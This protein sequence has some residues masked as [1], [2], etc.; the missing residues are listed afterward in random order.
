MET[1]EKTNLPSIQ[2]I[3]QGDINIPGKLNALNVL[4]NQEPPESWIKTHP[5]AKNVK[6]IQ[7]DK[8]EYLLT[9]I[10]ITWFVEVKECKMVANSMVTVIRLH[11][12]NPIT[13]QM[14]WTDGVGAAN[15]QV[16]SGAAASDFEKIKHNAV[17][18]AA[19][20]SKTAAVKDAAENLGKIFGKDLNRKDT[21]DYDSLLNTNRFDNA[22][23]TQR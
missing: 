13:D 12:K 3:Q 20:K 10:F 5:I 15:L 9:K 4:L 6:Y 23:A 11:Y 7:I 18:I 17:E 16:N 8:V 22:S 19:P 2:E 1:T 14:E 21:L